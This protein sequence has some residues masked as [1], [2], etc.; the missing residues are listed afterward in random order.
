MAY[1]TGCDS[2]SECDSALSSE[3]DWVYVKAM[4][5]G[6]VCDLGSVMEYGSDLAYDSACDSVTA[7]GME[8]KMECDLVYD[9]EM[10]YAMEFAKGYGLAYVTECCCH[11]PPLH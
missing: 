1:E 3:C 9:L 10:A 11:P 4:G 2:D 8:S 7:Y 6:W 5:C